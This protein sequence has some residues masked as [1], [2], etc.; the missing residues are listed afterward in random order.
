MTLDRLRNLLIAT[1]TAATAVAAPALIGGRGTASAQGCPDI[2]VVFARGTNDAPGLGN[3]GG[4]FV[5]ALQGKVGGRSVGTYAVN[6]PATFDFLQA[7]AGAN[8]ASGHIQYMVNTCPNTQLV[9]G[10]YS[11][12]A[13]V[14]DVIS[15]VPVPG[16]GF[17][18]PLPPNVPNHVAAIAVFGNPSAKLGLPLTVSGV[19][20]GRAIDLCNPG[21][22][23][24]QTNGEDI[25]AHRA[26]VGGPTNQAADFVASRL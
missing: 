15:A 2:E 8:D 25:A 9:L 3:V 26:Y 13:A 18:N 23:V 7:A 16:L 1:F 17:D 22:P 10:G 4:A 5:D 14:I 12:G 19:Y 11:Q 21:D 20:G 6:Y 24:C